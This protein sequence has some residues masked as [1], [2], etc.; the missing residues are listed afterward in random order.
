MKKDSNELLKEKVEM[1]D[2]IL[3][4]AQRLIAIPSTVNLP[5][6][7]KKILAIVEELLQEFTIDSFNHEDIHS[8][9]IHNAKPGTKKFKII[10]NAHLDVVAARSEQFK[11]FIKDGKLF[12]RGAYDMKTAAAVM[13][14]LFKDIASQLG[15]PIALQLSTDEENGGYRGV[16]HQI[17]KGVRA[18]FV[19]TGECGSNFRIIHQAKGILRTRLIAQGKTS[20]SAYPWRG[21]NAIVKLHHA[22]HAILSEYPLPKEE[23]YRTTVNVTHVHTNNTSI[24]TITPDHCEA[25]L[26]IRF[27]PG[28]RQA[29]IDTVKSALPEGVRYEVI[30]DSTPHKTDV[31]NKYIKILATTAK[32]VLKQKIV[33]GKAHGASDMRHFTE[34]NCDGVEFGPIGGNQHH[35]NEWVDIKSLGDYYQILKQFLLAVNAK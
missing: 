25:I 10:L 18:D 35:D 15:Y 26:D 11:P 13:I 17:H 16:G 14:F 20:H 1:I 8:L 3:T 24:N 33:F 7:K 19:I 23:I 21:E 28:E 5:P 32:E 34:V 30:Y 31:D 22:I 9:L 27:I 4:L 29:V 12:G 6:E 2:D